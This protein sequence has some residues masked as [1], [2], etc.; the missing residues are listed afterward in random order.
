[1]R[2]RN[3]PDRPPPPHA[4]PDDHAILIGIQDYSGGI[5]RLQGSIND[6]DL[7]SRWLTN[8]EGGGLNPDNIKCL[9]SKDPTDDQ[10]FRDQVEDLLSEYFDVRATTGKEV[11]RRL[12]LYFSGHGVAPPSPLDEDCAL[13]MANASVARLRALIG[14][15][16]ARLVRK[17]ALFEEVMLVMDCCREVSGAVSAGC[18]LVPFSTDPTLPPRPY[19]HVFAA[20]WNA[21][22][23]ERNLPDPIDPANGSNWHGVLTHALIRGLLTAP[24]ATGNVTAES[25]DDFVR[26]AVEN[27]LGGGNQYWP[28]TDWEKKKPPMDFGKS[29]GVPVLVSLSQA[30]T[31]LRVTHGTNMTVI[32]PK[33]EAAPGGVKLWLRPGLYLFDA[34]DAVGDVAASMSCK[35]LEEERDVVL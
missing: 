35:I 17:A 31:Q 30:G 13:V 14:G 3:P 33:Q 2:F 32:V 12:Y 4:H 26:R 19:F 16:A 5:A 20:S 28:T 1:M 6:C 8:R 7:F 15:L 34:V 10:P 27:M 18:D 22:A 21:T 24:D 9:C 29:D 23:A 11:G 25:L